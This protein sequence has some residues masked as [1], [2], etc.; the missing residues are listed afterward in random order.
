MRLAV[1]TAAVAA[2][3]TLG[4][5]VNAYAAP[6]DPV[7]APVTGVPADHLITAPA[8][9]NW[10]YPWWVWSPSSLTVHEG[11][12]VS[13]TT[14]SPNMQHA[15]VSEDMGVVSPHFRQGETWSFRFDEPG[16]YHYICHPHGWMEGKIIV[17]PDDQ[18]IER[19]APAAV[20]DLRV[21]D[22]TA[23][24]ATL[25]WTSV[26]DDGSAGRADTYEIRQSFRGPIRTRADWEA[27]DVVGPI[28]PAPPLPAAGEP[29]SYT[30]GSLPEGTK[31]WFAMRTADEVPNLSAPSNSAGTRTE[32]S[33]AR[34]SGRLLLQYQLDDPYGPESFA[35]WEFAM[36]DDGRLWSTGYFGAQVGRL[37]P[38]TR[39]FTRYTLPHGV[40]EDSGPVGVIPVGKDVWIV[41]AWGESVGRL[42]PATST[43]TRIK[44]PR[45]T[46]PAL[47]AYRDGALWFTQLGAGIAKYEPDTGK[48]TEWPLPVAVVPRGIA[49]EDKPGGGFYVW[50]TEKVGGKIGRLDPATN[51]IVKYQLPGFMPLPY[52]LDVDRGKV[53]FIERYGNG[54][55]AVDPA[56]GS[57]E[58]FPLPTLRAEPRD[59]TVSGDKV[60]FTEETAGR[61]GVLDLRRASGDV[62]AL[63]KTVS[64]AAPKT[65]T[66]PVLTDTLRSSTERTAVS[67]RPL[68][69]KTTG[70]ITEYLLPRARDIGAFP[71]GVI[72]TEVGGKDVVV[73]G[74][75]GTNRI[76]M[77]LPVGAGAHPPGSGCCCC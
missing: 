77:L 72:T 5:S 19:S 17:L 50:F 58:R 36:A 9:D 60:Y 34:P 51:E 32:R 56:A 18:P 3:L 29:M 55:G 40:P 11:D 73:F 30:V 6:D 42:D 75:Y 70:A 46:E 16:T 69:A 27:A 26:G 13:W 24:T 41:D 54:V 23:T 1:G 63:T 44:F 8:I 31:V 48:L 57:L 64:T 53:W 4:G 59:V 21:T 39:E 52:D 49:L 12:V 35:P 61:L 15:V 14:A 43:Y 20:T 25:E 2:V 74:E 71:T 22:R 33:G 76:S 62:T 10:E 38:R 47:G 67:V 66:P 37:D 7:G 65:S 68:P 45:F 28:T